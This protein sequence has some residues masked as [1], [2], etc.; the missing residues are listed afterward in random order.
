MGDVDENGKLNMIDIIALQKYILNIRF[1]GADAK[2]NADINLDGRINVF[3][4]VLLKKLVLG[5]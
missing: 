1:L 5:F 2:A 3:D 4:L